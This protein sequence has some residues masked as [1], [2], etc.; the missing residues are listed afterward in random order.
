[1][2]ECGILTEP[3]SYTV[4]TN[5]WEMGW[6]F[7]AERD[8]YLRGF[9]VKFPE[10]QTVT[11]HLWNSSG[12]LLASGAA[13]APAGQWARTLL[14]RALPLEAGETYTVSAYNRAARYCASAADCGF[15]TEFLSCLGGRFTAA[16]GAF[17]DREENGLIYPMADILLSPELP[18]Y[19]ASDGEALYTV[20]E[21]ALERL[22]ETEPTA[23]L[24]EERGT[25]EPPPGELLLTLDRPALLRWS[26]CGELPWRLKVRAVPPAQEMECSVDMSHASIAGIAGMTAQYRGAVSAEYPQGGPMPL[27]D[28]LNLDPAALY[29]GLPE[30]R[31]LRLRF[32]L[33][34]GA[35]LENLK[36]TFQEAGHA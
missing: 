1:M 36:F 2:I 17:P 33:E 23:E 35:A 12:E 9:R 25:E 27:E 6:A 31:T 15:N 34:E 30:D 22:E 4:R 19:L 21:G 28:F 26:D 20:R 7:R 14:P 32:T 18:K 5:K 24:F 10:A 11:A 13:A 3:S 16:E 8:F 29:A